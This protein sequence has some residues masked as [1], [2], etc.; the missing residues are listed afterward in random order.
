MT[1]LQHKRPPGVVVTYPNRAREPEH[2]RVVHQ[3]LARRLA[4]LQGLAYAG[5][6]RPDEPYQGRCYFLP[7]GPV[8]GLDLARRLGVDAEQDLFGGVVPEAFVAT[9]AITHCLVH[10]GAA[11]PANWSRAFGRQVGNCVLAG[12]TA[13]TLDDIRLAARQLLADG[14]LRIKPVLASAGRG[15]VRI[16][17]LATLE[18]HIA[19]LDPGEL[20][21]FGLVLE[22][23]LE[24]VTTI[25]VG[26][27]RIAG[28][29]LSYYGTQRLTR[30]NAGESV[31]GGSD[32]WVVPGDFARLQTLDL[33]DDMRLA[34]EQARRFDA[35][36]SSCYPAFFASRR[37]YDVALGNDARGRRRSGVLEQSWRVGGASSAEIAALEVFR[38]APGRAQVQVSSVELYGTQQA[39]PGA[40]VLYRGLDAEVGDIGK[41]VMVTDDGSEL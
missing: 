29:V 16:E 31:Y 20:A 28:Q 35:A 40:T 8:V 26:Q 18:V 14:P 12:Y 6:Y 17:D 5:E 38:Q 3:A 11:A 4:A 1:N 15:Q 19:G 22:Q 30:D 9:K 32:L 10:E 24:E 21:R 13:F 23:H 7:S 41:Y 27:V 25:S 33:P 34:I 36:A 37:N 2:E 39:P